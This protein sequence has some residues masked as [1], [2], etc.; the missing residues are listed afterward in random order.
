MKHYNKTLMTHFMTTYGWSDM[1]LNQRINTK[2]KMIEAFNYEY[3]E[4]FNG[5]FSFLLTGEAR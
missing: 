4:F 1:S 3:R 5:Q 2:S